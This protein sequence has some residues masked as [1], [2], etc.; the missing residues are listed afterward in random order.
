M[1]VD[2][3][4]A[5][6]QIQRALT[7]ALAAAKEH[8]A[9][10]AAIA[11]EEGV[12]RDALGTAIL[13]AL[14]AEALAAA[15]ALVDE[16]RLPLLAS[17]LKAAIDA[18]KARRPDLEDA[19][20]D[21]DEQSETEH[22][23]AA[24]AAR[25][26]EAR[27]RLRDLRAMPGVT[28]RIRAATSGPTV[29]DDADRVL[30]RQHEQLGAMIGA[31]ETEQS[32]LEAIQA[33]HRR[34]HRDLRL[35]EEE[36]AALTHRLE[37]E[38]RTLVVERLL[39]STEDFPVALSSDIPA[40]EALRRIRAACARRAVLG[41]LYESWVRPHGSSL[42]ALEKEGV[43]VSGFETVSYPA[44]VRVRCAD[45]SIA[46]EAFRS[47]CPHIV[48]VHAA[49]DV[50]DWWQRLAP[51]V[52]RPADGAFASVEGLPPLKGLTTP[53]THEPTGASASH[54]DAA[55]D[56]L[57]EAWAALRQAD[58]EVHTFP[59]GGDQLVDNDDDDDDHSFP[60]IINH[61][62]A[63]H[64][65]SN[66]FQAPLLVAG[67]DVPG[68]DDIPEYGHAS[69]DIQSLFAT[70]L[71]IDDPGHRTDVFAGASASVHAFDQG[72]AIQHQPGA[73]QRGAGVRPHPAIQDIT[74]RAFYAGAQ[75]GN[76]RIKG[77]IGKGGMGEVY[78][79][80]LMGAVGFTRE[81]VLKRIIAGDDA[82]QSRFFVREAEVTARISHP[83]V[84]EIFDL[85]SHDGE[86]FIVMEYLTGLS[87]QKLATRS[88]REG[89]TLP[90]ALVAR[91]IVD[92]ARGLA[93]AH[94]LRDDDGHLVGLVHRDVAPD[95][96]FLCQSGFTKVL[97]FGIAHQAN[98]TT[99]TGKH[100]LRGKIPFMSPEQIIGD[101]VDARSDLFS[102]G[103]TIYFL[104]SGK[105]P[106]TGDNEMSTLYA[107][108]NNQAPPLSFTSDN[109]ALL[110]MMNRLLQKR[111]DDRPHA[112]SEVVA[113]LLPHAASVEDAAAWLG[114]IE[115]L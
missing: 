99:M 10:M 71:A 92:A 23:K 102:L 100:E 59:H 110:R 34:A 43:N 49:D 41:V 78:R 15:A 87:L 29:I 48:G 36:E 52:P 55:G 44:K 83:N 6:D 5:R 108:V 32:R 104:L 12:A 76:F 107:V 40:V 69:L 28:E 31:M 112:A 94:T 61:T 26:A 35:L 82:R 37:Q 95:N 39:H 24:V 13:P 17:Q 58:T 68:G 89:W 65:A 25:L 16:R 88:W 50:N 2:L 56:R 63:G 53:A 1:D 86:P 42:L 105:R 84:V 73:N 30:A 62:G 60:D 19:I 72:I 81:V 109:E 77:L 33:R 14:S 97:D 27:Q 18:A 46:I 75:V 79:A 66:D 22:T 20:L 93:A 113:A 98:L 51:D 70:S 47:R 91:F 67:Q 7:E 8:T 21:A 9:A 114:R 101:D 45:A 74:K 11:V 3:K 106:F 38:A 85:Q 90:A 96:L 4:E 115:A 111:R 54:T 57:A 64:A 80:Q 103:S